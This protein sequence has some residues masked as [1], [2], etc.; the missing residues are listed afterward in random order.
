[1]KEKYTFEL[2]L[3][4]RTILESVVSSKMLEYHNKLKD[5]NLRD[6]LRLHF[7]LM[8]KNMKG[9]FNATNAGSDAVEYLA[10]CDEIQAKDLE[11]IKEC[12]F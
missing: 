4:E 7:E 8:L 10:F 11:R 5:E 3:V 2:T 9:I 12:G 1:M 6:N